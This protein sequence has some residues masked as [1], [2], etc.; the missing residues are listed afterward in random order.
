MLAVV[1]TDE[2]YLPSFS[3]ESL[4]ETPN[5]SMVTTSQAPTSK[6]ISTYAV[7]ILNRVKC[8]LE[9]KDPNIFSKISVSDQVTWVITE[10]VSENNLAVLYEG[11]TSWV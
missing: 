5:M 4:T 8:K 6:T 9:G 10:A 3:E 7:S 2:S 1:P 11:W